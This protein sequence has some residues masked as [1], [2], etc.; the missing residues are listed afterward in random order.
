M[1]FGGAEKTHFQSSR[2]LETLGVQVWD[3]SGM[4]LICKVD[5]QTTAPIHPHR[6]SS[7]LDGVSA[8]SKKICEIPHVQESTTK[9][10]M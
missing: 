9:F 1:M 7:S 10:N 5:P 4:V 8:F 6:S 2:P 3:H